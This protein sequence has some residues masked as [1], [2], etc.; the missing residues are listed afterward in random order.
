M[1]TTALDEE[2][3]RK[4]LEQS[5]GL[6]VVMPN[7]TKPS[8]VDQ[9]PT[10]GPAGWTGGNREL[11]QPQSDLSRNIQ[12]TAVALSGLPGVGPIAS[13]AGQSGRMA[14]GLAGLARAGQAANAA[15]Q[16][17]NG[18]NS[19][20]PSAVAEQ[21]ANAPAAAKPLAMGT[22]LVTSSQ[23]QRGEGSIP[24]TPAP[25]APAAPATGAITKRI[26]AD[27]VTEYS[28]MNVGLNP[29]FL[30]GSGQ[31]FKPQGGGYAFANAASEADK[32]KAAAMGGRLDQYG[33]VITAQ[34]DKAL[35]KPDGTRWNAN[36]MA[37]LAASQ[38]QPD[39]RMAMM[40]SGTN[41]GGFG[42]L[43]ANYQ[44][45]RALR[46]DAADSR[47]PGESRRAY[48]ARIAG[49]TGA[50]NTFRGEQT[51]A[52]RL[53]AAQKSADAKTQADMALASRKMAFDEAQGG[54]RMGLDAFRM[55]DEASTNALR[56]KAVQ[57]ELDTKAQ[58]DAARQEYLAAGDDPAKQKETAKKLAVLSGKDNQR[59]NLKDNFIVV[60]GGQ[61]YDQASGTM[62]NVPQTL[63]DLRT[64]Q[65][66]ALPAQQGQAK[67][68]ATGQ[69]YTVGQ[70][71]VKPDGSRGRV[72]AI[73]ANGM[74][75]E[76]QPL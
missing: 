75:T 39:S 49:A 13:L 17:A 55:Q 42:I 60:G 12:N 37:A 3:K 74:A 36:D 35:T 22:S 68:A 72:V 38:Q 5:G 26:G 50:L 18:I 63:V 23:S 29:E 28:G 32:A 9:I 57:A 61:E 48:E 40:G 44:R 20:Q 53:A 21:I 70:T 11:V 58:L 19:M 47:N 54:A 52:P 59:E 25:T 46:M 56:R 31:S 24:G 45:E 6:G 1:A 27:G 4:A 73:D 43:D 76:I 7:A 51:A 2:K 62:R 66:V 34:V 10:G 69:K 41:T 67:T 16:T 65:P 14:T 8:L 33:N 15:A 64:G 30:N 71:V